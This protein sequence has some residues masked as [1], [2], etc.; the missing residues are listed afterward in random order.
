VQG[1][2]LLYKK[3]RMF[4]P[5][6]VLWCTPASDLETSLL[7]P[8]DDGARHARQ[9]FEL[10]T[11]EFEEAFRCLRQHGRGDGRICGADIPDILEHDEEVLPRKKFPEPGGR[12]LP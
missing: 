12:A 8:A 9:L 11:A 6:Q 10:C 7:Q 2:V 5:R 3:Q 1:T 4:N